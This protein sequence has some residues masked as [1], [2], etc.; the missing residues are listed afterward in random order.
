MTLTER[1][2][3]KVNKLGPIHPVLKTRCW[4]WTGAKRRARGIVK[5]EGT[6]YVASRVSWLL[7]HGAWPTP[8][9]LHYCDNTLC[10]RPS[11]LH[12]GTQQEN[13]AERGARK[14]TAMGTQHGRAKLTPEQVRSIR[15]LCL[16][17]TQQS[18]ADTFAVE[19]TTVRDIVSRKNWKHIL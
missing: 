17:Q 5:V 18:V 19:R 11:H 1:F 15:L 16:S 9:C 2:W 10:I 8:C 4:L 7:T 14:R 12:E 13:M 6:L 3:A